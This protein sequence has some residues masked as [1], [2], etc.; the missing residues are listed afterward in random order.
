MPN[1]A[2]AIKR[3]RRFASKIQSWSKL[4]HQWS[5][6]IAGR[7]AAM[8]MLCPTLLSLHCTLEPQCR[9]RAQQPD[10]WF[11]FQT[12]IRGPTFRH[13]SWHVKHLHFSKLWHLVSEGMRIHSAS[14]QDTLIQNSWWPTT[15]L[16]PKPCVCV[17][18]NIVFTAGRN[19]SWK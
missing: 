5:T 6:S 7:T 11:Y 9:E 18:L 15:A 12:G 10:T 16:L 2:Q 19:F 1:E 4:Q 13:I 14:F 8:T 17:D 3:F